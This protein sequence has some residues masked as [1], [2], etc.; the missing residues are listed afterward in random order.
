MYKTRKNVVLVLV[1]LISIISFLVMSILLLPNRSSASIPVVT[2]VVVLMI[3]AIIV[4]WA[5]RARNVLLSKVRHDTLE[6]GETV[7][8]NNFIDKLRFC[9]SLYDFFQS[10]C[11][12]L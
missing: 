3:F 4:F 1:T 10:I 11:Y 7:I 9:Y 12:V 2:G 6:S 8:L 5:N